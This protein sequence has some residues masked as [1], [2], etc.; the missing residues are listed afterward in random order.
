MA[1]GIIAN[2]LGGKT[3]LDPIY[4]TEYG[5]GAIN[6]WIKRLSDFNATTRPAAIGKYA[7]NLD[8]ATGENQAISKE[9]SDWYRSTIAKAGS[10]DPFATSVRPA[11]DYAFTKLNELSQ[12]IPSLTR[13]ANNQNAINLGL[14]PGA[15]SSAVDRAQFSNMAQLQQNSLASLLP[16]ISQSAQLDAAERNNQ[17]LRSIGAIQGLAAE[18][19]R[20]AARALLPMNVEA[21]G[22]QQDIPNLAALIQAANANIK[23]YQ[24]QPNIWARLGTADKELMDQIGQIAGIAGSVLGGATGLGSIGSLFGGG[25]TGG[26]ATPTGQGVTQYMGSTPWNPGYQ[27]NPYLPYGANYD[28]G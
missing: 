23:G 22:Y 19:D 21:A 8:A 20:L 2:A 1:L 4:G 6:E 28:I 17:F 5:A 14:A 16:W 13:R 11:A 12:N 10:Y 27:T 24:A 7:A 9:L 18:P 15:R 25:N 26:K 3:E